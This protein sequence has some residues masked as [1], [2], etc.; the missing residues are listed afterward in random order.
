MI[1][2]IRRECGQTLGLGLRDKDIVVVN[3]SFTTEEEH[4][5][6]KSC[7][8]SLEWSRRIKRSLDRS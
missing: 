7:D 8:N 1:C 3:Y 5:T 6:R 2:V 4:V